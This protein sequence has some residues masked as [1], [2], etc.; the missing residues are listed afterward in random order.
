MKTIYLAGPIKDIS[1][2]EAGTWRNIATKKL[3]GFK[4]LNPLR[5]NF[6]DCEFQ[7]QNE[8][9]QLDKNDIERSDILLVNASKPSAGTSMEIL[10]AHD[11]NKIIVSYTNDDFEKTSPWVVYHS[12]RIVKGL[13]EAI[14]YIK[15]QLE[16]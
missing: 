4:C 15:N 10:F 3:D 5:R 12:T 6:R 16:D 13:D 11:R 14:E 9:V 8:I 2:K 1:L 7:S